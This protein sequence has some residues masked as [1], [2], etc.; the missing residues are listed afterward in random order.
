[1]EE[2]SRRKVTLARSDSTLYCYFLLVLSYR[3]D[4]GSTNC[5]RL[6]L[7]YSVR[8]ADSI[9]ARKATMCK[10]MQMGPT[11]HRA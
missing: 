8:H 5:S 10:H 7:L 11:K 1:M 6:G 3:T 9:P 4:K 2:G